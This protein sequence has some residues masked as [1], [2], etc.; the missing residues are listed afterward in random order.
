MA[1]ASG[2][3]D[4]FPIVGGVCAEEPRTPCSKARERGSEQRGPAPP[5]TPIP[6]VWTPKGAPPPAAN[7]TALTRARHCPH[8]QGPARRV[9]HPGS[10]TR[11]RAEAEPAGP[12]PQLAEAGSEPGLPTRRSGL[13]RGPSRTAVPSLLLQ[14]GTGPPEPQ[15]RNCLQL[16]SPLLRTSC[17]GAGWAWAPHPG[18]FYQFPKTPTELCYS[19]KPSRAPSC[20]GG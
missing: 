14:A 19:E 3:S 2:F 9:G 20:L 8:P 16:T 11:N 10:R 7:A 18:T 6:P 12:W 17:L 1:G 15:D 4:V 13:A 5:S